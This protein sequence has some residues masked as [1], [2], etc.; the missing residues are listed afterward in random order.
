MVEKVR[1]N[2]SSVLWATK[3]YL[4]WDLQQ[5][6]RERFWRDIKERTKAAKIATIWEE[7]RATVGGFW[8]LY[9]LLWW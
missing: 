3:L 7:E 6:K 8:S 5:L 4:K 2:L 1:S 9:Q